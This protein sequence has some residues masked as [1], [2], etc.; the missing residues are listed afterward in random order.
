[1]INIPSPNTPNLH[2]L[3]QHEPRRRIFATTLTACDTNASHIPLFVKIAPDLSPDEVADVAEVVLAMAVNGLVVSNT[4]NARPVLLT[5][6]RRDK[7]GG[8]LGAPLQ[9]RSTECVR[10]MYHLPGGVVPIIGVGQGVGS[11][12]VLH[13]MY[14]GPGLVSCTRNMLVDLLGENGYQSVEDVGGS[15]HEDIYWGRMEES[16]QRLM[17]EKEKTEQEIV[18]L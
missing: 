10:A 11:A 18:K 15:D 5:L 1:M 12:G 14:K 2:F 9:E 17:R 7:A 13:L 16:V 8:L 3:Q 4:T 6:L